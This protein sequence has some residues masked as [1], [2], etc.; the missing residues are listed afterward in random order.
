[1]LAAGSVGA[2]S[3]PPAGL[4][5]SQ[6]WESGVRDASGAENGASSTLSRAGS[7]RAT[8][9]RGGALPQNW[10]LAFSDSGEPYYIE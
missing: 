6:S 9:S 1:M 5:L 7:T 4:P 2:G 10:E 3:A 8:G